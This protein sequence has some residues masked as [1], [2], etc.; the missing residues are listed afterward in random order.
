LLNFSREDEGDEHE[1]N[2]RC[3]RRYRMSRSSDRSA[4]S[5][6]SFDYE[7]LRDSIKKSDRDRAFALINPAPIKSF[8][9]FAP[10]RYEKKNW[11][12]AI[13]E[14]QKNQRE[15]DE[16][17]RKTYLSTGRTASLHHL[18]ARR[19]MSQSSIGVDTPPMFSTG[20]AGTPLTNTLSPAGSFLDMNIDAEEASSEKRV[21]FVPNTKKCMICHESF[22]WLRRPHHCRSCGKCV[23][24]SCSPTKS[25]L[26]PGEGQV[27]VC[28]TC[29]VSL[30]K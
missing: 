2:K 22:T 10:D 13:R 6:D 18:M 3:N 17:H 8:V 1:S 24:H 23:C 26:R 29:Y 28:V 19:T 16:L 5:T 14:E 4:E 7:T 20:D 25:E 15:R 27:R 9:V 12:D 11:I 30:V 21:L